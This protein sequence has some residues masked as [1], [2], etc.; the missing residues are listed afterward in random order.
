M[1][2]PTRPPSLILADIAR[3]VEVQSIIHRDSYTHDKLRALINEC[4]NAI[5]IRDRETT[6]ILQQAIREAMTPLGLGEELTRLDANAHLGAQE[7][8]KHIRKGEL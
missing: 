2:A 1:R 4:Q 3:I 7:H 5:L 8:E 6:E